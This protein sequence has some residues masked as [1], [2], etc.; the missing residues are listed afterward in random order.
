[1]LRQRLRETVANPQHHLDVILSRMLLPGYMP[2]KL[3]KNITVRAVRY[4][5]QHPLFLSATG[6]SSEFYQQ[7][8]RRA[9]IIDQ[10]L[11]QNLAKCL[12]THSF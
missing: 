7:Q 5:E 8:I 3:P 2:S 10:L 4:E 11:G 1:M 6:I 12:R 9:F